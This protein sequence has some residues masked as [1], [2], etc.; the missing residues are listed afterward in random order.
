MQWVM[1]IVFL[2]AKGATATETLAFESMQL[3]EDARV[4]VE[5]QY[6][7]HALAMEAVT[8]EQLKS[9]SPNLVPPVMTQCV[10]VLD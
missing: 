9:A 8:E 2:N 7:Q 4:A 3:C 10:K 6:V 5:Q 1:L